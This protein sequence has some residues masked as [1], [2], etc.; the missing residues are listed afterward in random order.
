MPARA[1]E[2]GEQR[3][4]VAQ[5]G[6]RAALHAG[7]VADAART[8]NEHAAGEHVHTDE[9]ARVAADGDEAAA[10]RQADLV[11]SITPD[12]NRPL[13]HSFRTAAI[14]RTDEVPGLAADMNQPA[15]HF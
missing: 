14:G 15:V 3:R 1:T 8:E 6:E 13:G 7:A 5:E 2:R 10:H 11:A 12:E 4:G 9:V